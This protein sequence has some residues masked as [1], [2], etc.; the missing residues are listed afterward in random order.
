MAMSR[1]GTRLAAVVTSAGRSAVWVSGILRK[2]DGTPSELAYPLVLE[3]L[4]TES[5]SVAWLDDITVGVLSGIGAEPEVLELTIGGPSA[6]TTAPAGATQLAGGNQGT[7]R[8]RSGD[9]A[10][11]SK[12]GSTWPQT[13]AGILVLAT[14]QG[15]PQ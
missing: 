12:R 11:Y 13:G 5:A 10:L 2:A 6:I 4:A 8:V 14:Q 9:G 3:S 7:M 1:D 15:T